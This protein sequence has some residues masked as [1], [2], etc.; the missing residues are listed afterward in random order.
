MYL[1]RC[2]TNRAQL[3][4]SMRRNILPCFITTFHCQL[5][6][7]CCSDAHCGP[8]AS[9]GG[10]HTPLKCWDV[11]ERAKTHSHQVLRNVLYLKMVLTHIPCLN[12]FFHHT[13]CSVIAMQCRKTTE[14]NA[15]NASRETQPVEHGSGESVGSTNSDNE[16][17]SAPLII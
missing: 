1:F 9:D 16:N 6:N 7:S 15:G 12:A 8:P 11:W 4:P 10:L 2:S 14:N 3:S 13:A 17:L 5:S